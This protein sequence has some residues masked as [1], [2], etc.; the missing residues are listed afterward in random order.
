MYHYSSYP[1]LS[2]IDY[3]P[4]EYNIEYITLAVTLIRVHKET[5]NLKNI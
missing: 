2:L 5:G 4:N 3:I 1:Q